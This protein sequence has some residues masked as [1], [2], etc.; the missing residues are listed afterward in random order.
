MAETRRFGRGDLVLFLVVLLAAAGA[1]AWYLSVCASNGASEGPLL[2]Q[3]PSPVLTG[4]P[5][6]TTMHGH[7][8][9]TELDAL[10]HN[11]KEHHWFGSLAPL[12]NAESHRTT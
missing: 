9:P 11:L 2:V 5:P 7:S 6:A 10:V 1:R 8:P 3:D 4:L 12:A